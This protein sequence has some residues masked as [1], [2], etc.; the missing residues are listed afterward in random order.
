MKMQLTNEEQQNPLWVAFQLLKEE[1]MVSL[2]INLMNS[3]KGNKSAGR[4]ARKQLM[5]LKVFCT[6]MR[7]EI[8]PMAKAT[9]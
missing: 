6:E 5:K 4:R 2:E 7:K 8:L 1:E 3:I 9:A